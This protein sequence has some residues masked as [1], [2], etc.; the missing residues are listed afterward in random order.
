MKSGIM[1]FIKFKGSLLFLPLLLFYTSKAQYASYVDPF[2][3]SEGDGNVFI[4]PSCPYGM[5][6][7]GPDNSKGS[8]S[9]YSPDITKT[10]YGFSQVHVSGTGGG[11]KYGN[12]S[13]MPFAGEF[14]NTRQESLR[15]DEKATL[16]YYSVQLQK[17]NIKTEITTS[18]RV[19]YYRFLFVPNA[20][21]AVKIDA[22]EFL[23][24]TPVPDGR[25]AQQFVG[26][27]IE[28]VNDHEVRGYSRIRGGW[29]NG[30]AYTVYFHA[31]FNMPFKK[32]VTWK[33]DE[34]TEGKRIQVDESKKTGVKLFFE[35]GNTD[36]VEMKIGISFISELKAAQNISIEIPAWSFENTLQQTR[37]RWEDLL[38]RIEVDKNAS[39]E[40][41]TMFYTALYHTMLMPVDRTGENPLWENTT[42][43]Y[44]DFYAIWDTYRSSMP[45]IT[46]LSPSRQVEIVNALLQIYKRDGYLPD[47]RSGN[48]NGR[49]QG[50]S[51]AE[52]VIADAF[53][54]GLK[55]INYNLALEAMMKDAL[56]PPGG[57]EEAEGRGGL[58]DY[59][60]LGYVSTSY[61]RSGNRT[62]EY[63]YDDYC[64]ATVAKGIKRKGEYWRFFKQSDNWQNLWRNIDDNGATGFIMPKDVNGKWVDSFQCDVNNGRVSK[65]PYT[66]TAQDW[67]NC[68]CWWCGFFYEASSWEYSLSIPHDVAMLITKSG[69]TEAFKKR[70]NIFFD[71]G[72][73]NVGNEPSFLSPVL[74]HWIGR[75][76][77]SSDRVH[78]I[79]DANYNSSRSG[80]PGNDDSGAMSSWL[81][82]HMMGFYPNA[83]QPY[84]LIN[85]PYFEKTIIHQENGKDF[86]I[87][88]INLS[89]KN[90][91][92]K[93]ATL[94]GQQLDK[95]FIDH[96]DIVAGGELVLTM[97]AVPST[98]WGTK[99]LP[100]SKSNE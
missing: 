65:I 14:E 28:V 12:I 10:I 87:R 39:T 63:A 56:I 48:C 99:I 88:T 74:Y 57:N 64:L 67:P 2:I 30:R 44:D 70:L 18:P 22:G 66:P 41:K 93:S 80:I 8:N 96:S 37:N 52:V 59:N 71:K 42:P 73:Y 54:K 55:N 45:L 79:V 95:A 35:E 3:G 4:G 98:V 7:P 72:F 16:G 83:G 50:G 68:V 9:G 6:K 47:S 58:V 25:E 62:L 82:F 36:T 53:V 69:G 60:N 27:E 1:D 32:F 13:V 33:A 38:K 20:N 76:D 75:P 91:Y 92:I 43:Y 17:Y 46:L 40:K 94:N 100:P 90:K 51:N 23:G 84:Y 61:V 86:T 31:V 29:N 21:K 89:A 11:P 15:K 49:T 78:K 77:L 34:Q 24:E 5:V 26:S 19:A 97:D 81:A 85:T